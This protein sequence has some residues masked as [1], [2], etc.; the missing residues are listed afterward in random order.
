MKRLP[1]TPTAQ[2]FK[3]GHQYNTVVWCM[4]VAG[5]GLPMQWQAEDPTTLPPILIVRRDGVRFGLHDWQLVRD[6]FDDLED[7]YLPE[8]HKA[9]GASPHAHCIPAARDA[10]AASLSSGAPDAVGLP[11]VCAVRGRRRRAE[12]GG[13]VRRLPRPRARARVRA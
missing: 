13:R 10:R 8:E 7:F 12:G 6:F 5:L 9:R 4:R 11:R 3:D 1:L 2:M